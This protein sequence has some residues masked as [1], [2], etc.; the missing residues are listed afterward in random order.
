MK[1]QTTASSR[2]YLH[3]RAEAACPF[4]GDKYSL[5]LEGKGMDTGDFKTIVDR[6]TAARIAP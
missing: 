6:I 3:R 1:S 2:W 4:V 5:R